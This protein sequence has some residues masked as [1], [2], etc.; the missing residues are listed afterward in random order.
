[1][2][3]TVRTILMLVFRQHRIRVAAYLA[4]NCGRTH[5]WLT[6]SL[7]WKKI[8]ICFGM[9]VLY[10][11]RQ[12]WKEIGSKYWRWEDFPI[13]KSTGK[14]GRSF[15]ICLFTGPNSFAII[16]EWAMWIATARLTWFAPLKTIWKS[17]IATPLSTLEDNNHCHNTIKQNLLFPRIWHF[18]RFCFMT[19]WQCLNVKIMSPCHSHR[20][21]GRL[22]MPILASQ[23]ILESFG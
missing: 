19:F 11:W 3:E 13:L 4:R 23:R 15:Q 8:R 10:T 6:G 1:M 9:A 16:C 20:R 14:I 22:Y 5:V 2:Y 17:E 18:V 21:L 7:S 12:P